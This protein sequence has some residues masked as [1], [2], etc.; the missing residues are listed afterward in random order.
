MGNVVTFTNKKIEKTLEQIENDEF[1]ASKNPHVK[2]VDSIDL[3]AVIGLIYF[4]GL[5]GINLHDIRLPF[6]DVRGIPVF[7]ATMSRLRFQFIIAHLTFDDFEIRAERWKTDRF[8]AIRGFFEDCNDNFGAALVPEDYISLDETL[9]PM[10]TKV[11]SK[12]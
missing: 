7:G 4:R 3:Y 9:Y 8:A 11:N 1:D 2:P 12:Q 6:S 10:R 5:Y